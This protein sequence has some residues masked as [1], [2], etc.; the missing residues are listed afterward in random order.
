MT[1]KAEIQQFQDNL[2]LISL[3]VPIEGFDGFIGAWVYT[4]DP[5]VIV[6]VGPAVTVHHL[7]RALAE[8][9]AGRPDAILLTHIHIDHAGGVGSVAAAFP[10]AAVVCHSK[11]AAHLIEPERLWK[12]S[13]KTLGDIARAY[14]PIAPLAARQVVTTDQ[15]NGTGIT[16][17]ETPGHAVHHMS[18]MIGDLLFAGEAGGVHLP[19]DDVAVYL[20]PATPPR[21]FLETSIN[22]IDRI[23]AEEPRQICYG[24][25]GMRRDAAGLLKSHRDQLQRW[26]K[27]VQPFFDGAQGA[28]DMTV[29][30]ACR[31][32]LLENDPLLA[33]FVHLPPAVR[34]RERGFMINALKGYWGYLQENRK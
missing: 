27:M 26:R 13:L 24:H 3:P 1:T 5:T 15:F 19:M 17:M 2:Y 28:D 11:G 23:L 18:Y 25:T 10:D 34:Q 4:G 32:H 6:D 30:A 9:D 7:L 14:G 29:M 31:Q 12:G 22:S 21:F 20:R 33:G 16:C 8:L